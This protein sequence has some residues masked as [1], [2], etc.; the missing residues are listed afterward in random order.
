MQ[1]L[2]RQ[3]KESEMEFD[4]IV[5]L[6]KMKENLH[7]Y[8]TAENFAKT[9]GL[10]E[11]LNNLSRLSPPLKTMILQCLAAAIQGCAHVKEIM[12]EARILEKMN[13]LWREE[14]SNQSP[15]PKFL[16]DCLLVVSSMLRNYPTA[17]NAFFSEQTETGDLVVFSLLLRT[18][19]S[20]AWNCYDKYCRRLKFRIFRL[21]GDLIDERNLLDDTPLERRKV[22]S[23]FDLPAEIKEHGWC[24]R[25]VRLVLDDQLLNTHVN[26]ESAIEAGKEIAQACSQKDFFTDH[27][28]SL[29]LASRLEVLETK[30][31]DLARTDTEDGLG[32]YE[33][34]RSLVADFRKAVYGNGSVVSV[35]STHV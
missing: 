6:E 22:Y 19:E 33:K 9:G 10:T 34:V 17:Q 24:H 18:T 2:L 11:L 8:A 25:V 35:A 21:L 26:V 29:T 16:A 12:F 14:L 28:E 31:D 1:D 30:Y 15:N 13:T 4:K 5:I 3:Y 27:Q 7:E 32:Y 23:K 20:S